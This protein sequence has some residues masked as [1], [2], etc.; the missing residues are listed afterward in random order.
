MKQP[1]HEVHL[2]PN[3]VHELRDPQSMAVG[4]EHEGGIPM[5]MAPALSGRLH[6]GLYLLGQE[7][8][9]GAALR[10]FYPPRW[11]PCHFRGLGQNRTCVHTPYLYVRG[12]VNPAKNDPFW[13]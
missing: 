4:E 1:L 5:P 7:V 3:K 11:Q 6:Q 10:V 12:E 8:L 13:Q 9:A 2:R